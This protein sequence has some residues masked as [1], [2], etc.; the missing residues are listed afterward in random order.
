MMDKSG[1]ALWTDMR[2]FPGNLQNEERNLQLCF[3][4]RKAGLWGIFGNHRVFSRCG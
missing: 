4:A 3:R 2:R 1:K